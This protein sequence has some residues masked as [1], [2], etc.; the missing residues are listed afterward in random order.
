ML[1]MLDDICVCV[2]YFCGAGMTSSSRKRIKTIANKTDKG[3]KR[4]EHVYSNKFLSFM[5]ERHFQI[6]KNMRLLMERK[7]GL[8]PTM[9]P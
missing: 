5:H 7:V 4:K 1:D 6:V 9:A 2:V 8:I 3:T